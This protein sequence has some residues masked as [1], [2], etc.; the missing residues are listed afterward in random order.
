MYLVVAW[1]INKN[2]GSLAAP[3]EAKAKPVAR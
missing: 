1:I 2:A 3:E